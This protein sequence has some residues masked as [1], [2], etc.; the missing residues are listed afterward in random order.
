M[1][2][3]NCFQIKQIFKECQHFKTQF[4]DVASGSEQHWSA[5]FTMEIFL[6]CWLS[7][8]CE[9]AKRLKKKYF[10]F[11][12]L[13]L[14]NVINTDSQMQQ[15]T[16]ASCKDYKIISWL[17]FTQQARRSWTTIIRWSYISLYWSNISLCVSRDPTSPYMCITWSYISLYGYHVILHLRYS[18]L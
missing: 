17:L 10:D 5:E 7:R 14:Q 12:L 18:Y 2:H 6:N 8:C 9:Q 4:N 15:N 11:V 3:Q 1:C 13:S 16:I